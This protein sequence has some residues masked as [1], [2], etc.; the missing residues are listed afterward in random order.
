MPTTVSGATNKSFQAAAKKIRAYAQ[1]LQQVVPHGLRLIGEEIMTDIKASSP[2]HGVPVDTGALRSTGRVDQAGP[3]A[4]ELS[5]GG[6]AAPY[7]LT[8][9]EHVEFH[10]AVGE[11]RYLVR[12]LERWQP[13]GSAAMAALK[14]NAAEGIKAAAK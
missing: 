4:I 3:N 7:A 1:R 5:F 12:G 2:G 10:H 6:A 14:Q 9:H 13:G 8:Q 11:S